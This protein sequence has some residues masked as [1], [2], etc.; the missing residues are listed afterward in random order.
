MF[1]QL[2]KAR[3]CWLVELI[4]IHEWAQEPDGSWK[5]NLCTLNR[6]RARPLPP[7]PA[8]GKESLQVHAG[9]GAE[10]QAKGG[11]LEGEGCVGGLNLFGEGLESYCGRY[12][13]K[14]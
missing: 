11:F 6:D 12:P 13:G 9:W 2:Q 14:V 1:D 8:S 4:P 3:W 7:P 5:K 10:V